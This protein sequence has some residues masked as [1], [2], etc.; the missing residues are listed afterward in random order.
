M[1]SGLASDVALP[2]FANIQ[3]LNLLPRLL[4]LPSLR[5]KRRKVVADCTGH[6][7]RR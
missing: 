7:F 2:P 6:L 1:S 3:A 5:C 4:G